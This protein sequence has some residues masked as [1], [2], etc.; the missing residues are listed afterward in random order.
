MKWKTI[1]VI[2]ALHL[3][4]ESFWHLY[5]VNCIEYC[6]IRCTFEDCLAIFRVKMYSA[7][8]KIQNTQSFN[9][10]Q[11][12]STASFHTRAHEYT[13]RLINGLLFSRRSLKILSIYQN[14]QQRCQG[15]WMCGHEQA[16][17]DSVVF[18]VYSQSPLLHTWWGQFFSLYIIKPL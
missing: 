18:Y 13:Y 8:L 16:C 2:H 17:A 11:L 6:F 12:Q 5:V 14:G 3:G 4:L 10:S 9:V 15:Y 7:V 1:F